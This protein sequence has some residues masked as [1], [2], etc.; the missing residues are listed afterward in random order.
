MM[1]TYS[2]ADEVR[3]LRHQLDVALAQAERIGG[4]ARSAV[5]TAAHAQYDA[6]MAEAATEY[7]ARL[8]LNT[9]M[10]DESDADK[11]CNANA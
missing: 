1:S 4:D 6:G 9:A 3:M 11:E 5:I 7:V 2:Y 8:A 10:L